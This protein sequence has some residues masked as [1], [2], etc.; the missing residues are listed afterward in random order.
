MYR[1][2]RSPGRAGFRRSAYYNPHPSYPGGE[3]AWRAGYQGSYTRPGYMHFSQ[4]MAAEMRTFW[5]VFTSSG[6]ATLTAALG[7]LCIG[8][9]FFLE[10]LFSSA[11][12]RNN[13]GKLFKSVEEDVIERKR[14]QLMALQAARIAREAAAA[15][16]AA[17][18][19]RNEAPTDFIT[20][21]E[22]KQLPTNESSSSIDTETALLK[23]LQ[24]ATSPADSI[25]STERNTPPPSQLAA[26]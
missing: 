23:N 4:R 3:D 22:K 2:A 7:G 24:N 9:I 6:S 14:A 8:G 20:K 11:W 26:G 17:A 19:Q 5:R 15:K 12:E 1:D 10:P 13:Q 25:T 16:T 18:A 21:E